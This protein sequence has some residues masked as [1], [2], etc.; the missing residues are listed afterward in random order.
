MKKWKRVMTEKEHDAIVAELRTAH[1]EKATPELIETAVEWA[2]DVRMN[3]VLLEGTIEGTI[4][5]DRFDEHG[6]PVF[7]SLVDTPKAP[8]R[9][10]A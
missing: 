1:R 8:N 9:R 2:C 3:V 7:K 6:K 4:A 5:F 10:P